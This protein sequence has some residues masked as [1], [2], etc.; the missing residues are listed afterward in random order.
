MTEV[1]AET[2]KRIRSDSYCET[3]G[4]EVTELSPGHARTE[5]GKVQR[6]YDHR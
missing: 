6:V 1:P 2:R 3:L 4:I 5:V